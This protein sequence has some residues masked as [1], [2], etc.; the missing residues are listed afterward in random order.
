[1]TARVRFILVIFS[2]V[3]AISGL[4]FLQKKWEIYRYK[5]RIAEIEDTYKSAF[6]LNKERKYTQAKLRFEKA[7]GLSPNYIDAPDAHFCVAQIYILESDYT[8]AIRHY[9]EIIEKFANSNKANDSLYTTGIIYK[10]FI[11]NHKKAHQIFKEYCKKYPNDKR[12]KKL[13]RFMK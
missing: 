1:M 8:L 2:S 3:V 4:T 7:L 10:N 13:K 11:G 9:T 5:K 6:E 12:A